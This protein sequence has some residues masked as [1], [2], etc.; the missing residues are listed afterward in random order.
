M[1][2]KVF[3][4]TKISGLGLFRT[5]DLRHFK[6]GTLAFILAFSAFF[7]LFSAALPADK[8]TTKKASAPS[9]S[10]TY[11]SWQSCKR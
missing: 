1:K 3:I 7:A 11:A 5:G 10:L 6:T 9:Y 4:K 8:T 2:A